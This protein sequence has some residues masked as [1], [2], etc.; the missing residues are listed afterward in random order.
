L[1]R[2]LIGWALLALVVLLG[3][4]GY[5][6]YRYL[7]AGQPRLDGFVRVPGL[8]QPVQVYRDARGIPHIFAENEDDLYRATG[9]VMAQDRL[10]Q[11]DLTRRVASGRLAEVLGEELLEIDLAHRVYGFG[12]LARELAPRADELTRRVLEDFA[13]GVNAGVADLEQLPTEFRLLGYEPEPWKPEDSIALA[14]L[15]G[16]GLGERLELERLTLNLRARLGDAL[17]ARLVPNDLALGL[18]PLA[19][20]PEGIEPRPRFGFAPLPADLLAALRAGA[21]V[22]RP[23]GA[24]GGGGSN[25][26]VVSGGRS[27]TGRPL[28]ANDPHLALSQPSFWYLIHQ[29]IPGE[30]DVIGGAI[31]GTPSVLIGRNREIAWGLTNVGA[32]FQDTFLERLDPPDEPRRYATPDGWAELIRR[33]E[34]IAYIDADGERQTRVVEL[35]QTANGTLLPERP[36]PGYGLALRWTVDEESDEL[37]AL[38]RLNRAQDFDGFRTALATFGLP[39]QN[40][41]F[42]A[43]DGTVGFQTVGFIPR[44]KGFDGRGPVPGWSGEY[45]WLGRIP[46]EVLPGGQAPAEGFIA[47]ANQAPVG[48]GYPF[49][50]TTS[51]DPPH[52]AARIR[53]R[54]LAADAAD[55]HLMQSIQNDI[56]SVQAPAVRDRLVAAVEAGGALAGVE[57][58][59]LDL[60]R[61]WDLR[62]ERESAAALI[63]QTAYREL[64]RALLQ[65]ELGEQYSGYE[66]YTFVLPQ[67]VERELA[68]PASPFLDDRTTTDRRETAEALYR[69]AFARA[70]RLLRERAGESPTAWRWDEFHVFPRRH[71]LGRGSE[72][73]DLLFSRGPDGVAGSMWTPD[74]TSA[75]L[76]PFGPVR[77]GPSLRMVVDFSEDALAHLVITGGQSGHPFSTHYDDL[78]PLWLQGELLAISMDRERVRLNTQHRLVLNPSPAE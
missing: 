52:R 53:E 13:G 61:E 42:A 51:P 35:L 36:A 56:T 7:A 59:A 16:W 31:P 64:C 27:A 23:P 70:V 1:I 57:A 46:Y 34:L 28:L 67:V 75:R 11:M 29:Q 73:A 8:G 58:A 76:D 50:I 18:P 38:Y 17:T 54:L 5:L 37:L 71:A 2:R 45:G 25:S 66:R 69:A 62:F 20:D 26:W 19:P 6:A 43:G 72:I 33:E 77:A 22:G 3:A 32:D 47:I 4:A 49:E 65:D 55:R 74:A 21:P 30:L 24:E 9:Y 78:T 39:P 68:D 14:R 60:L 15:I 44:R 41:V 40:I 48:P 12:R 63:F 10:F